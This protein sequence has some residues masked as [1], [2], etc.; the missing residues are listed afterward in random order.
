MPHWTLC[1]QAVSLRCQQ[2]HSLVHAPLIGRPIC[3]ALTGDMFKL[4]RYLHA[5][6]SR[7]HI[8]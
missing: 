3:T 6:K 4:E 7:L 1:Q 5:E 2:M 8:M